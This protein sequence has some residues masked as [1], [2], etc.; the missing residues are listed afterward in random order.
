MAKMQYLG[1]ICPSAQHL[2]FKIPGP[3]PGAWSLVLVPGPW[4][5]VPWSWS[6]VLVTGGPSRASGPPGWLRLVKS[7]WTLLPGASNLPYGAEILK[8]H[9]KNPK[10]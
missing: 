3:G 7:I 9:S 1:F 2:L 4:S 8:T 10:I 5:L 6:L